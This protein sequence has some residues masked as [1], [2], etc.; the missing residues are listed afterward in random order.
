MHVPLNDAMFPEIT[1]VVNIML[2]SFSLVAWFTYWSSPLISP[3]VNWACAMDVAIRAV[4]WLWAYHLISDAEAASSAF[5]TRFVASLLEH[6]EQLPTHYPCPVQVWQLGPDLT[7][8][9]LGG[10]VVVDYAL[11]LKRE[12]ANVGVGASLERVNLSLTAGKVFSSTGYLADKPWIPR[13]Y[14]P[15]DDGSSE[16]RA[17]ANA[18]AISFPAMSFPPLDDE[19]VDGEGLELPTRFQKGAPGAKPAARVVLR[20]SLVV[21]QQNRTDVLPGEGEGG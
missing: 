16:D 5:V 21:I 1:K 12:Y 10:E 9:A 2:C 8:V 17:G 20:M 18:S 4:N 3:L 15:R 11:R 6:G 19:L 13:R 14:A 7:L